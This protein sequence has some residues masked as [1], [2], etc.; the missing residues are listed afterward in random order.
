MSNPNLYWFFLLCVSRRTKFL[1]NPNTCWFSLFCASRRWPCAFSL[2]LLPLV[3]EDSR[4]NL[5]KIFYRC[6]RLLDIARTIDVQ[7]LWLVS[8]H[9]RSHRT[10]EHFTAY[11]NNFGPSQKAF[12]LL[13]GG[14]LSSSHYE[15]C[16]F[17]TKTRLRPAVNMNKM[18]GAYEFNISLA[19]QAIRS[20]DLWWFVIF[21]YCRLRHVISIKIFPVLRDNLNT[22]FVNIESIGKKSHQSDLVC[23]SQHHASPYCCSVKSLNPLYY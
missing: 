23:S 10:M 16:Y 15:G 2:T 14:V 12:W 4:G 19:S 6:L 21:L 8:R 1:S 17:A 9:L 5:L 20:K 22:T 3:V 18:F 11:K 7:R 13:F